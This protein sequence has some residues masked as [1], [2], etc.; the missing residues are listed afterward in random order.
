M[1]SGFFL[2]KWRG[3]VVPI[4]CHFA[5]ESSKILASRYYRGCSQV[6]KVGM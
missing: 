2:Q 6:R 5:M 4:T 3:V 1:V